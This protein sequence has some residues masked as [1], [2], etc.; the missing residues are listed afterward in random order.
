MSHF[1]NTSA[2][3]LTIAW[4]KIRQILIHWL[5]SSLNSKAHRVFLRAEV[6]INET[7]DPLMWLN[8]Q[9]HAVKLYWEER[10][11]RLCFAG[12]GSADEIIRTDKPDYTG[13]YQNIEK[14]LRQ[15][16][17]NVKYFGGFSFNG[18]PE[19]P[20]SGFDCSR[21]ILPKFELYTNPQGTFAA[22]N[23]IHHGDDALHSISRTLE[24]GELLNKEISDF[25]QLHPSVVKRDDLPNHDDWLSVVHQGITDIKAKHYQKIVL[26]RESIFTL[27]QTVN[28]CVLLNRLREITSS[29]TC[30]LLQFDPQKIFLG[31]SPERLFHLNGEKLATEAIAGTRARGVSPAD[32]RVLRENLLNSVK[33]REEH[34]HVVEMIRDQLTPLCRDIQHV[35]SPQ[36]LSLMS[37]H[38]LATKFSAEL[39]PDVSCADILSGLHPTPAVA[40]TPT[41]QALVAIRKLEPFNRGWYAAPVGYI[42]RDSSEFIVAIRCGLLDEKT[43]HLYSGAGIVEG[44][45][46][47][48]E[49]EEIEHK[50]E[51]FLRIFQNESE[52][53]TKS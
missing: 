15:A 3:T 29:C 32:D 44:S 47:Q 28:P 6:S 43:L 52:H 42:G 53:I 21:F 35:P 5:E 17:D 26:A 18:R 4:E 50:I 20:W 33:D 12:I 27:D 48:A 2:S 51:Q 11:G 8:C 49:W 19:S 23:V 13:V 9:P 24:D 16:S 1:V 22:V 30:F 38:H 31:A 14:S 7:C 46:P 41:E 37:G 45:D 10:E 34:R 40:G 36:L 25:P 39:K